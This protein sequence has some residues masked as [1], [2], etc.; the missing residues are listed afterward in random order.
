M[1]DLL[2]VSFDAPSS[3][4]FKLEP[5]PGD[6]PQ[7]WGFA[8]YP[9]DERGAAL[10]GDPTAF[11]D[12]PGPSIVQDWER[13]RSSTFLAHLRG[14]RPRLTPRD[15]QPFVKAYGGRDWSFAHQGDLSG[16]WRREL[17]LSDQAVFEPT[18]SSD[19]ERAFCW[20]LEWAR[21]HG[22]RALTEIGWQV[23]HELMTR[24]G[25]LGTTNLLLSDGQTLVAYHGGDASGEVYWSRRTPPHEQSHFDGRHFSLET[26]GPLDLS[27]S[28]VLVST[29][30]LLGVRWIPF[31]AGQLLVLRRGQVVWNSHPATLEEAIFSR[32]EVASQRAALQRPQPP[33]AKFAGETAATVVPSPGGP[34]GERGEAVLEVVHETVYR[35]ATPVERSTHRFKLEP[36]QDLRQRLLDYSLEISSPGRRRD[37]EDVFGNRVVLFDVV[38]PFT[39]LRLVSRARVAVAEPSLQELVSPQRRDPIPLVWM[40]W[41]RQ[42][43]SPYLLP[44]ELPETQLRELSDYAMGFVERND[45]DLVAT[46]LDINRTL[47]RDFKYVSG[48]TTIETTPF[49]VYTMR[50]G[51]C[52]DFANL[53][54]MLARLLSVP[55]RYRVGYIYTGGN[56]ENKIQS[57]ASHA[58]VEIYLP[59]TGWCGFDPTNGCLAGPDHV[60]VACGRHYWD[61]APTS[62]TIYQGGGGETL[63]V[64]VEVV[65]GQDPAQAGPAR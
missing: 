13:F 54:I 45:F 59:W 58:W 46:L 62:G 36:V 41:Q 38:E 25:S 55:A 40:P 56:Y 23:L 12:Q 15:A 22:A 32:R 11:S 64:R 61:A 51:V 6:A 9:H 8:W 43:M 7:R 34:S 14:T 42:M 30:P 19:S 35:Y 52:Q 16:D 29:Q 39:E 31:E 49:D 48:S 5:A 37:Y 65:D 53:F 44:A 33:L 20:L 3:P 26:G 18:G 4:T 1:S 24:I 57:E 27:R 28:Y 50:R 10:I 17:A 63:A 2:A 21:G 47:Y 60:R